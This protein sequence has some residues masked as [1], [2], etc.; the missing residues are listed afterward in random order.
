M[1]QANDATNNPLSKMIIQR[2]EGYPCLMWYP[3]ERILVPVD[4]MLIN[5]EDSRKLDVTFVRPCWDEKGRRSEDP[6]LYQEQRQVLQRMKDNFS[7][8]YMTRPTNFDK[9]NL[10]GERFETDVSNSKLV[11]LNT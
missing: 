4:K 8:E 7:Y 1:L 11:L 10:E 5:D 2:P 6:K 3:N 9:E